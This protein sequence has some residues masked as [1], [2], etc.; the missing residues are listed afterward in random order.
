MT[1]LQSVSRV[2]DLKAVIRNLMEVE[3]EAVTRLRDAGVPLRPAEARV[4]G[5]LMQRKGATVTHDAIH[6]AL[7]W[8]RASGD[9]SDREV[10]KVHV[11]HIRRKLA[12]AGVPGEL[13]TVWGVGYR[14]VETVEA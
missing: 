5:L 8:D 6:S 14:W 3:P 7:T 11:Y 1:P 4:L 10:I 9:V 2:E 12:S 13:R